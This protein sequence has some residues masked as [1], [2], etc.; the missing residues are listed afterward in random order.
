MRSQDSLAQSMGI[1]SLLAIGAISGLGASAQ[2]QL[3]GTN[4][5][6]TAQVNSASIES[7]T[8][9]YIDPGAEILFGDGEAFSWMVAG[10]SINFEPHTNP[11]APYAIQIDW[12]SMHS[13]EVE[14]QLTLGF[15]L[16]AG[17]VYTVAAITV[18]STTTVID[19][20]FTGNVLTL[21]IEDMWQ[22]SQGDF[23]GEIRVV[24]NAV[25]APADLN[26]DAVVDGA[27]LASM[28][29]NWGDC[30]EGAS[31]TADLNSDGF[32]NGAD[33]ATLLAN[34]GAVD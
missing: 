6:T 9:A 7:R 14:D 12:G 11:N 10:D 16:E 24:F 19:G 13:F 33:L 25:L 17:W 2:A 22:V 26:G 21:D 28:L 27:D 30:P 4:I 15:E 23:G 3:L 34:W 20:D 18:A 32:V 5:T 1:T 8:D 31:C 29:A